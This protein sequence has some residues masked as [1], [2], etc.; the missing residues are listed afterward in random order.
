MWRE[1]P[2][3]SSKISQLTQKG[4]IFEWGSIRRVSRPWIGARPWPQSAW[5]LF[6]RHPHGRSPQVDR[7]VGC[8]QPSCSRLPMLPMQL[9]QSLS[10]Y[11]RNDRPYLFRQPQG[12]ACLLAT[13]H[14]IEMRRPLWRDFRNLAENTVREDTLP[15]QAGYSRPS[16][17]GFSIP[18]QKT[19]H[20]RA[21]SDSRVL[22]NS[23]PAW[24][25][26]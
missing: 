9:S 10:A 3:I 15:Q 22:S 8:R 20:Q 23:P 19:P 25:S 6:R 12:F 18:L 26:Q 13:A 11:L 7:P 16:Q 2:Q 14:R 5:C 4:H 21:V 24:H 1:L 17:V